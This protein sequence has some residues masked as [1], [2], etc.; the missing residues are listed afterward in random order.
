MKRRM[1]LIFRALTDTGSH[2]AFSKMKSAVV[3]GTRRSKLCFPS[4]QMYTDAKTP[5]LNIR[6][7]KCM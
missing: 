3:A 7:S 1:S 2:Y 5:G 6:C 4:S